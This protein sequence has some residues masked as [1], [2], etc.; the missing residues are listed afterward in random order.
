MGPIMDRTINFVFQA[1]KKIRTQTRLSSGTASVSYAAID[2]IKQRVKLAEP[3]ILVVGVGKP[4][5]SVCKNLM[6]YLPGCALSVSNRTAT[7]AAS[8]AQ[9]LKCHY[10]PLDG[11]QAQANRF[12]VILLSTEASSPILLP[13]HLD[14][15]RQQFVLDLAVPANAHPGIAAMPMVCFANVDDIS[16]MMEATLRQR[17]AEVPAAEAIIADQ[18][19]EFYEWL[20]GYRHSPEQS[21][22]HEYSA[23]ECLQHQR[24]VRHDKSGRKNG[25]DRRGQ[26]HFG[27]ANQHETRRCRFDSHLFCQ[28]C[29][30]A[31]GS[32]IA[33]LQLV[34]GNKFGVAFF[35]GHYNWGAQLAR[36]GNQ[37]RL[38]GGQ[39]SFGGFAQLNVPFRKSHLFFSNFHISKL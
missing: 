8:L 22:K 14:G 23:G 38:D 1:S 36:F 30:A 2:W 35:V 29:S 7:K 34:G 19:A 5:N 12:D 25:L 16:A 26:N 33:R 15:H 32:V 3:R 31:A 20:R 18:I 28:R 11:W 21:K 27:N 39:S 4:G 37:K 17:M 13:E 6:H 9:N 24:R 10:L